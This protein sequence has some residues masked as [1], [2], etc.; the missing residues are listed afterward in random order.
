MGLRARVTPSLHSTSTASIAIDS[1]NGAKS[2]GE[3][4]GR[5]PEQSIRALRPGAA[6]LTSDEAERMQAARDAVLLNTELL[7]EIV[8]ACE[9]RFLLLNAAAVWKLLRKSVD[10][11]TLHGMVDLSRKAWRLPSL[12]LAGR[13][14]LV[15]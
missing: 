9:T 11:P 8:S 1:M 3:E 7:G 10:S 4:R 6:A 12:C 5:A 15:T 2:K 14:L 13:Q